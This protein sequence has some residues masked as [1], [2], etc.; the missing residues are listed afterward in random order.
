M[1]LVVMM[2]ADGRVVDIELQMFDR[3]VALLR[4]RLEPGE[5]AIPENATRV[6]YERNLERARELTRRDDFDVALVPLLVRLQALENKQI[7]LDSLADIA[8]ADYYR[9]HSENDLIIL[10]S[11]FWGLINPEGRNRS[12]ILLA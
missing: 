3:A 11:A 9:T 8:D 7:L 1:L 6:W 12:N 10:A 5:G 4:K 2:L